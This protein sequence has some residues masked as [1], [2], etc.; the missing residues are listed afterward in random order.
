MADPKKSKDTQSESELA[1]VA[2][3]LRVGGHDLH[4]VQLEQAKH[5][6][7]VIEFVQEANGGPELIRLSAIPKN[8]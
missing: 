2:L 7:L 5:H 4:P 8:A 6:D 3:L 1:L